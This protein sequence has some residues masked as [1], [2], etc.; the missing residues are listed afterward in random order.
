MQVNLRLGSGNRYPRT[1]LKGAYL[2]SHCLHVPCWTLLTLLSFIAYKTLGLSPW[3]LTVLI[4]IRPVSAALA[5]YWSQAIHRKPE[6]L[7]RNLLQAQVLRYLPLALLPW[8]HSPHWILFSFGL[9]MTMQRACVPAWMELMKRILTEEERA[10]L[11]SKAHMIDYIGPALLSIPLAC[12]LDL[13]EG[14]WRVLI[15]VSSLIGF[16]SI[17]SLYALTPL[18]PK[19]TAPAAEV[20]QLKWLPS[21]RDLPARL[22]AFLFEPWKEALHL[23]QHEP[24][25]ARYLFGIMLGGAGL[26]IVQPAIPSFFVDILHLSY[27]EMA[28]AISLCRAVGALSSPLWSR[29]I[30]QMEFSFFN[31]LVTTVAMFWP[32]CMLAAPGVPAYLYLAYF[33]YGVMQAG[34]ELGWHLSGVFFAKEKE[35]SAFSTTNVLM[36]GLRGCLVP[37]LGASLF[38]IYGAAGLL[39]IGMGLSGLAAC[40]FMVLHRQSAAEKRSAP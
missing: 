38:T 4:A 18:V 34:S 12:L 29:A 36:V 20:L 31:C 39:W 1:L 22:T 27:K 28:C 2:A 33:L 5:P 15:A 10:D 16:S 19:G 11:L 30:H 35:S 37:L 26:M 40:Y 6:N 9:T 24:H 17:F 25:F 3:T 7:L 32:L 13:H 21:W 14:Y 8:I 23:L